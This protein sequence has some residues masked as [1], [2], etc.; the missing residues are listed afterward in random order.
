M[1]VSA[2]PQITKNPQYVRAKPGENVVFTCEFTGDP[3][4]SVVWRKNEIPIKDYGRFSIVI[5]KGYSELSIKNIV[6]ED[7]GHYQI[8]LKTSFGYARGSGIIYMSGK[9]K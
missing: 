9:L 8:V 1:V 5:Q 3:N 6:F 2:S 4:P 7:A